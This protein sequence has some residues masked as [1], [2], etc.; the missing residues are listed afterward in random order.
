MEKRRERDQQH[1]GRRNVDDT[2]ALTSIVNR[3]DRSLAAP[4]IIL[5]RSAR[6]RLH[7]KI[8]AK[9]RQQKNKAARKRL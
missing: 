8:R 1:D 9:V 4:A 7:G 2:H 3:I 5:L 6:E